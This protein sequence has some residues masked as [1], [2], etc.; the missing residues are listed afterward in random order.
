MEILEILYEFHNKETN[1][2]CGLYHV[3][4]N[5]GA[6]HY[7][8][9]NDKSVGV[10]THYLGKPASECISIIRDDVKQGFFELC[11]TMQSS[12]GRR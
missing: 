5:S 12:G 4:L 7:F 9:R 6:I 11:N 3:K 8:L 2:N 1:S 10:I